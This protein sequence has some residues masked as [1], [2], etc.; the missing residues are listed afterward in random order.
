M[1]ERE[2]PDSYDISRLKPGDLILYNASSDG[3]YKHVGMVDYVDENGI[4]HTIEG[5]T[6]REEDDYYGSS[7]FLTRHIDANDHDRGYGISFV[8]V[9]EME[10]N[11]RKSK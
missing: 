1:D 7:G 8:L 4:I 9:N 11:D 10:E 5:N 2:D 6:S 3:S